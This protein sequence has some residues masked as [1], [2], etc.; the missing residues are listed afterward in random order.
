MTVLMKSV[1]LIQKCAGAVGEYA[2]LARQH[3]GRHVLCSIVY[4][5]AEN[6]ELFFLEQNQGVCKSGMIAR[7]L[8]TDR[9]RSWRQG[10]KTSIK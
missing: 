6:S 10:A 8:P 3:T 2:S 9:S 4:V 5:D 1:S 7:V